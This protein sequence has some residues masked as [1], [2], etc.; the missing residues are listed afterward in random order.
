MRETRPRTLQDHWHRAMAIPAR[1]FNYDAVGSLK[2]TNQGARDTEEW[3]CFFETTK[4]GEDAGDL[5]NVSPWHDIPLCYL[6]E[7]NEMT[8]NYVNEIP[9]GERAKMECSLKE[10]WNPLKQDIKKGKLRYFTYG[11]VPFNYGFL[12]QTFE[13]PDTVSELTGLVGD[14]DPIDVVELSSEPLEIGQVT[15]LKVLGIVGM[16]DEGETDWKVLGINKASPLAASMNSVDDIPQ[17]MKDVVI[18]WFKM[19]KT[20]DGKPENSFYKDGEILDMPTT[21]DIVKEVHFTWMNLLLGRKGDASKL[22]LDSVMYRMLKGQ[23]VVSDVPPPFLGTFQILDQE[24][25][26]PSKADLQAVDDPKFGEGR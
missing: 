6:D 23:K 13:C 9:K 10:D 22:K 1:V 19:Y 18:D 7:N 8:F 3:R 4:L 25:K 17:A 5:A 16:I 15:S 20:T 2:A 21:L 11:D 12:P 14:G 26:F 24:E